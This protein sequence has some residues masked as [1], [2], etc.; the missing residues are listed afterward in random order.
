MWNIISPI[1]HWPINE[2]LC[3]L[4]EDLLVEINVI[5]HSK[6]SKSFSS[7]FHLEHLWAVCP[8]SRARS[9]VPAHHLETENC[10]S[11]PHENRKLY[12]PIPEN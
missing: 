9:P 12:Q 7:I 8:Q 2:R 6:E 4:Y 1:Q 11:S 10:A 3:I 5:S